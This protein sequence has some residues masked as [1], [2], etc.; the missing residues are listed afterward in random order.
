MVKNILIIGLTQQHAGKTSLAQAF[1]SYFS[2]HGEKTCG[3]KP[4]SGFNYWYHF[5]MAHRTLSQGRLY[6]KD[7]S[8]L[9]KHSTLDVETEL[10]NPIHRLWNEPATLEGLTSIPPFIMDRFSLFQNEKF[11]QHL[12]INNQLK[13]QIPLKY[14]RKLLEKKYTFHFTDTI[15]AMNAII[16]SNYKQAIETCYQ[17]IKKKATIILIESYAD[18]A[19]L[20]WRNLDGFEAVF[21][22]KPWEI[23]KYDP[24]KYVKAVQLSKPVSAWETSTKKLSELLKPIQIFHHKPTVSKDIL[25]QLIKKVP[26]MLE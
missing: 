21:G 17:H 25:K 18:N 13:Q 14:R 9:E 26:T 5:D 12:L 10:L 22:I 1:L 7:I 23:H 20:P 2:N 16:Q 19:L 6:S 15:Q 3:F 24:D 11:T 4:F 8:K